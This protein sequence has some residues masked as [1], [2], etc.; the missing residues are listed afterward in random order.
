M[1]LSQAS[2]AGE[3][4]SDWLSSTCPAL[5]I[6]GSDSRATTAAHLQQMA[7]RRENTQFCTLDGG[8]IVHQDNPIACAKAVNVFSSVVDAE[9]RSSTGVN[10]QVIALFVPHPASKLASG[11]R[12]TF[13]QESGCN[14][15]PTA[16]D[17]LYDLCWANSPVPVRPHVQT[18]VGQSQEKLCRA[19]EMQQDQE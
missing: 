18:D 14:I 4:W 12:T 8:H 11:R 19:K 7:S 17:S 5:V 9:Y 6:R 15:K 3:H 1:M 13:P 2:L 16:A 10:Q